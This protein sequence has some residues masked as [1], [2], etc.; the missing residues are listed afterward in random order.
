MDRASFRIIDPLDGGAKVPVSSLLMEMPGA[1]TLK[2]NA[3]HFV[4]R[5][6]ASVLSRSGAAIA[7]L[8]LQTSAPSGG[9]GHRTSLRGGGPAT[10]LVIPRRKDKSPTLWQIL[11]ANV[12][13]GFRIDPS[14]ARKAMPWLGSNT[15]VE[16]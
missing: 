3:D 16:R 15:H 9:A 14:D 4:K 10:T 5:G 13:E 2:D 6:G 1:Q 12:P 8:T 11:W 7:L